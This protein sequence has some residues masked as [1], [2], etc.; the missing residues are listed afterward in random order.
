MYPARLPPGVLG[1]LQVCQISNIYQV[2]ME[3]G[4]VVVRRVNDDDD[5]AEEE[6]EESALEI[7]IPELVK[8]GFSEFV[9]FEK[10]VGAVSKPIFGKVARTLFCGIPPKQTAISKTLQNIFG[11]K[12]NT[13]PH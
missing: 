8:P 10:Q 9:M 4:K 11:H 7:G 2:E 13:K 3:C 12:L 6:E 1:L 5:A